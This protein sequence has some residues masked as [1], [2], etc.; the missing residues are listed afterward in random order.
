MI[1]EKFLP[2]TR[3]E[4]R[5]EPLL[6]TQSSFTKPLYGTKQFRDEE[7]HKQ[8]SPKVLS[9][10]HECPKGTKERLSMHT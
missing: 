10:A 7:F 3:R 5:Y 2:F 4:Q 6:H 8:I 9:G 1:D